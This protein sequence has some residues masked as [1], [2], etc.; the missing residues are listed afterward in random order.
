MKFKRKAISKI[1]VLAILLIILQLITFLNIP[2]FM[3]SQ[4]NN[5]KEKEIYNESSNIDER[6][7]R[8]SEILYHNQKF[9]LS[10]WW[11]NTFRYRIGFKLENID[12]FDRYQPVNVY[13]ICRE[14]EH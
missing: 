14:N 1:S 4:I 12:S 13:L 10:D 9:N 7:L 6:D 11:N 8:S 3:A 2:L 5:E